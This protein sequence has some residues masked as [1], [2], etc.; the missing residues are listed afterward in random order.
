MC[1]IGADAS[2]D[3]D[4]TPTIEWTVSYFENDL[5]VVN[6]FN[7]TNLTAITPAVFSTPL[8]V[9]NP[10]LRSMSVSCRSFLLPGIDNDLIV[11]SGYGITTLQVT[12]Q[13]KFVF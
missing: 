6:S 11:A 2:T 8:L 1:T 12:S 4:V 5:P 13:S 3:I 9:F 10:L 7:A